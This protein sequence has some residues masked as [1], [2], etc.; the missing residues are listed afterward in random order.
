MEAM[1]AGRA[2]S[3][4]PPLSS[5]RQFLKRRKIGT[6]WALCGS[7]F[8]AS[9]DFDMKRPANS[10]AWGIRL[11]QA[12]RLGVKMPSS[13]ILAIKGALRAWNKHSKK[14]LS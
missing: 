5:D 10:A 6:K 4:A 8:L 7:K 11:W 13:A 12:N 1:A 2:S 14:A 3:K 9:A